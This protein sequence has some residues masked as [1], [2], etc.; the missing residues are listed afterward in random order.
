MTKTNIYHKA[1][2]SPRRGTD[3]AIDSIL[4]H[5]QKQQITKFWALLY[6]IPF[7][8]SG[9]YTRLAQCSQRV[10]SGA[11]PAGPGPHQIRGIYLLFLK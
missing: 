2:A 7:P 3:I 9:E 10:A 1:A 11:Y 8:P 4:Q 5:V 6:I